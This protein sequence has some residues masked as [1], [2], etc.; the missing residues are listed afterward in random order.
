[1]KIGQGHE[2]VAYRREDKYGKLPSDNVL[3]L[4][5]EQKVQSKT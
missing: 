4:C 5:S 1:M 3:S 2:K